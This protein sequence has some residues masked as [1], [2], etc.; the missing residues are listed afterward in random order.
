MSTSRDSTRS[1]WANVLAK[2]ST[3]ELVQMI[4]TLAARQPREGSGADSDLLIL[5]RCALQHRRGPNRGSA[6]GGVRA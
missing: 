5:A 1:F 3:D 4:E 6:P 2:A